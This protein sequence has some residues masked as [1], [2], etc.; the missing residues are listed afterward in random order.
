MLVATLSVSV[1][2]RDSVV[3]APLNQIVYSFH[4]DESDDFLVVNFEMT[5]DAIF[6]VDYT[7]HE[8]KRDSIVLPDAPPIDQPITG[9][10]TFF[11]GESSVELIVTPIADSL[12]ER[13]EEIIVTAVQTDTFGITT[14]AATLIV[15]QQNTQ[16]HLVDDQNQLATVDPLTGSVNVL[17]TLSA[18][19]PITD[20]AFTANGELFAI[21]ADHLYQIHPED[22]SDGM[23]SST[24]LGFHGI[25]N[26]N[27]LIDARDG[28]FGSEAGDLFAVG[29]S[30]LDLQRI[31]LEIVEE[32]LMLN[33]VSTVFNVN[34]ALQAK[35]LPSDYVA[36]GDLEYVS[37]GHLILSAARPAFDFDSLIE[38]RTPGTFGV[39]ENQPQPARDPSED[40]S[41]INGLAFRGNDSFGF[42]GHTIL[43][44]NQFNR[45]S[46]RHLEMTGRPYD[47]G[48]M[49][50]AT[51]TIIGDPIDP[52]VVTLNRL[53]SDPVNLPLGMQPT[54]WHHQRSDLS[55]IMIDLGAAITTI[56]VGAITLTNLGTDPDA[57]PSDIVLGDDQVTLDASGERIRIVLDAGQLP[58]G[59]YE[60]ELS[61]E[62]TSG[63]TFTFT[64]DAANRFFKISGD[65]DGNG[66]VDIIDFETFAYWIGN[67][68]P[69]APEYVDLNGSGAITE[70]DFAA[71]ENNF[72]TFVQLPGVP[73]PID[74]S[75]VDE[76][77]L[78]RLLQ[79]AIDPL[80]VNGQDQVSPSDALS[81]INRLARGVETTSDWRF[82]VNRDGDITPRDALMIINFLAR[83]PRPTAALAAR[84]AGA[85]SSRSE[86]LF[87]GA[88]SIVD[89]SKEE[90]SSLRGDLADAFFATI[91]P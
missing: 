70:G 9:T 43:S 5:G 23:I 75:L 38:I 66:G 81:V 27:S 50:S 35:L 78:Q 53:K 88:Q 68:T 28:D 1:E 73:N 20:I 26:A 39:I 41:R 76:A 2:A 45:D 13:D 87:F 42:T 19:Q 58:D 14:G 64:G 85:I 44:I 17:G 83:Q 33:S 74:P 24:F 11:P 65:W 60:L 3:E 34:L 86:D 59:R 8:V 90:P 52:P 67:T 71:F 31:D 32:T 89:P 36:S 40:F 4:R 21:S 72:A 61:P 82:D 84:D 16:Y 54:S 57:T 22:V 80:N 91:N 15:D 51:G 79:S 63:E 37:A 25:F 48:T 29:E 30:F 69:A 49:S 6:G 55:D 77:E 7:A 18:S 12:I 46:T 62:I 47:I 56:P 10:A